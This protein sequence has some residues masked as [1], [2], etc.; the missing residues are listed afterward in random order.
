VR[1]FFDTNVLVASLWMPHPF[2][3]ASMRC[4]TQAPH[5]DMGT[6]VTCIAEALRVFCL[7]PQIGMTVTEATLV[8][9]DLVAFVK[10][11]AV[12]SE[13]VIP[14]LK[15]LRAQ[16]R[17]ARTIFDA[18]IASAAHHHGYDVLVTWNKKDFTDLPF[19][20]RIATPEEVTA[21]P[22]RKERK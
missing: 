11:E 21:R 17:S 1:L 22:G 7:T 20:L 16:R 2:H 12:P 18:L 4:M 19:K 3:A 6:A 13:G 15:T 9:E 10:V 5:K 8:L 14:A